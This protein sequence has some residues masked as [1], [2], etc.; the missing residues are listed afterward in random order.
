MLLLFQGA[1]SSRTLAELFS[2]VWAPKPFC[3]EASP[4]K[5]C[6]K[7]TTRFLDLYP[8]S[9]IMPLLGLRTVTEVIVTC[10]AAR[11]G[12]VTQSNKL[13]GG[14]CCRTAKPDPRVKISS[15]FWSNLV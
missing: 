10:A 9:T 12:S 13:R 15:C 3:R 8:F 1:P 4:K 5:D 14:D 2:D 6:R 11:P 7:T